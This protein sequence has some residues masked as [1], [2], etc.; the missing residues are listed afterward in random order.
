MGSPLGL[1][2][3][4]KKSST[5]F[6]IPNLSKMPRGVVPERPSSRWMERE[7]DSCQWRT[8]VRHVFGGSSGG[9]CWEIDPLKHDHVR[10]LELQV[11]NGHIIVTSV[12]SARSPAILYD[13]VAPSRT[14][15]RVHSAAVTG[16]V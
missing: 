3:A 14:G 6:E 2:T 15:R 7:S 1:L 9:C 8:S 12:A 10:C 11:E 5:R 13:E 4:Y 16:Q